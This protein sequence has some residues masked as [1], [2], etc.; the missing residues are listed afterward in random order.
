MTR[1][2]LSILGATGSIGRSTLDLV[3]RHPERFEVVALTAHGQVD[4]LADAVIATG[5]KVAAIADEAQLD[6]LAARLAGR[7]VEVLGGGT[8]T[9]S[10]AVSV[11]I[12]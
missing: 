10:S 4:A 12:R 3:G 7:D 1:R 2:R 6:A 11:G 5:A 9:F 8:A